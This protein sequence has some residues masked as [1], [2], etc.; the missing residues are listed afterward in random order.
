M[1]DL[2]QDYSGWTGKCFYYMLHLQG[3]QKLISG[4]VTRVK[5]WN[6]TSARSQLAVETLPKYLSH[7]HI[8]VRRSEALRELS[9]QVVLFGNPTVVRAKLTELNC[10]GS[11]SKTAL[12]TAYDSVI[13]AMETLDS[14]L[15]RQPTNPIT[16]VNTM[17]QT[18]IGQG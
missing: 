7:E 11:Y 4:R 13:Q 9:H 3:V 2:S 6:W 18:F 8:R 5:D 17:D 12:D 16:S 10:S 1:I 15:E 14:K